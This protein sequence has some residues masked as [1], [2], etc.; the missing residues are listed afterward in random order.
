M[1]TSLRR[2]AQRLT[3]VAG[4]PARTAEADWW[5]SVL[6]PADPPLGRRPL[7]TARDTYS[8]ARHLTLTLPA[9]VTE[10][11]LTRVPAV[12]R[13]EVNDVLLA[14]F[15][16]AWARRGGGRGAGVLLDLEG[17]GREEELVGGADLSRT[18]GWFTSLHPVRVDA[19]PADLA[20]AFAGGPAAGAVVK[21]V[22]EQ[23]REVPEKGIGY[24]LVRHLNPRT[25]PGFAG[26]PTP[27][28]AFNYL[29]RFTTAGVENAGSEAV[30]DWTVLA[31]ASGVGGTDPRVALA[32]PLELNARTND[33]PRG[34]EL[35]ATWSWAGGILD[36]D[37]VR[38]LAELWFRA[39]EALAD[40]A[41]NPEAGGLTV[42]DVS[43]SLL[44]QS[45]IE[46][47]EDEWR[48]L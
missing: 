36:E 41:E 19:G 38:E 30:P 47:L 12:F 13:A 44:D 3:E 40:H 45:E 28:V 11:L 15:A 26:L 35:S 39:L 31:T 8:S 29:G 46:L 32:H 33:G 14:A 18:V 16:L 23:L 5:R 2:W 22:K 6:R 17:H 4:D 21:R 34:P 42:S 25:A 20:D 27:Q 10:R 48:N 24:G 7:D 43:L 1:G 37:E 9:A